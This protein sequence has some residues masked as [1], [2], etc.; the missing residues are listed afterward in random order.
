MSVAAFS[1]SPYPSTIVFPEASPGRGNEEAGA[2]L[3]FRLTLGAASP[4]PS[5]SAGERCDLAVKCLWGF[6]FQ[7][8]SAVLPAVTPGC[9]PWDGSGGAAE[10][11]PRKA[12]KG[13]SEAVAGGKRRGLLCRRW[14]VQSRNAA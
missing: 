14:K 3:R 10:P 2:S 13:G 11:P 8:R 4:W 12:A 5:L 9:S 7:N 1:S 6:H